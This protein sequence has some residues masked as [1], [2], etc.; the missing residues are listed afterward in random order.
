MHFKLWGVWQLAKRRGSSNL[1]HI[2]AMEATASS[3]CRILLGFR[4][5]YDV[6]LYSLQMYGLQMILVLLWT[7]KKWSYIVYRW[8]LV[9]NIQK[10]LVLVFSGYICIFLRVSWA[11][12][13]NPVSSPWTVLLHLVIGGYEEMSQNIRL[14]WMMLIQKWFQWS[15]LF[16]MKCMKRFSMYQL[17]G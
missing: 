8:H 13:L 3:Y 9:N 17:Q 10:L 6:I 2:F 15:C 1:L 12:W 11:S 7:R 16:K 4:V 5:D 14:W